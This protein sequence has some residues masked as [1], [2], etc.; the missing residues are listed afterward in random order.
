[1]AMVWKLENN[2]HQRFTLHSEGDDKKQ[3]LEDSPGISQI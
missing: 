2:G 1:M 3:I